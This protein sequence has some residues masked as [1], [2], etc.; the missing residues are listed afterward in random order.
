MTDTSCVQK[1]GPNSRHMLHLF[2]LLRLCLMLLSLVC[3]GDFLTFSFNKGNTTT[4]KDLKFKK[5]AFPAASLGTTILP[6]SPVLILQIP[7]P[8]ASKALRC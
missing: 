7:H 2:V 3:H 5:E 8:E 1:T 6:S 4:Q